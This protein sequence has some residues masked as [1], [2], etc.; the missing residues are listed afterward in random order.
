VSLVDFNRGGVPLMEI[1]TEPVIHTGSQAKEYAQE[2]QK[3]VR[4]LGISDCDMEKGS[5]RLEANISWGLTLDYKVEVKNLNSFR[6]VDKAINYELKRQKVLLDK[7][8]IPVQE[9]RGWNESK[10]ETFTQRVK[11][12]AADYRYFP[13]PDIPPMEFTDNQINEIRKNIPELP[14]AK[15]KRYISDLGISAHYANILASDK[16]KSGVFDRVCELGKDEQI[17]AKDIA[18]A[19]VNKG[20]FSENEV[21]LLV[22]I[23][24]LRSKE[25]AGEEAVDSAINEVIIE[26]TK[27]VEDYKNGK[28]QVLGFLMGMVQRKVKGSGNPTVI[29]DKLKKLLN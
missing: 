28:S 15:A 7:G 17:Q 12:T 18:N 29:S 11:E 6:F 5:M 22:K 4:Y 9:T 27:A 8:E 21:G 3:I 16:V 24:E 13:E 2:L 10:G 23:K 20:V 25:F 26:N 1:V 14:Q 19:I